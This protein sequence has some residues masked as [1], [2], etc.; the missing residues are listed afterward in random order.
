MKKV[1]KKQ[2]QLALATST[3]DVAVSFASGVLTISTTATE[4]QPLSTAEI[5]E[6]INPQT[7]S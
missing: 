6:I 2:F 3:G 7:Q 5:N 1:K 4:D